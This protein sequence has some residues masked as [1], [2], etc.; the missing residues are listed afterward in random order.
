MATFITERKIFQSLV[1]LSTEQRQLFELLLKKQGEDLTQ[2]AIP[3]RMASE[4]IPLSYSQER[5]WTIAQLTPDTFVDNVPG[6]FHISG[7]LNLQVFEKSV[8]LLIE[9]NEI[10]RTT[11]TVLDRQPVQTVMTTF[12]PWM[13]TIDLSHVSQEE[14][15]ERA[16]SQAEAIARQPFNLSQDVLFRAIVF[17]LGEQEFLVL[18]VTHQ[19][20]TDGLSF[21]FLLQ[22]LAAL[23][24]AILVGDRSS[25]LEPSIQYADFAVWQRQWFSD[26]IFEPQ[27]AY[28]KQQLNGA[29]TQLK[30]PIYQSRQFAT[31]EAGCEKFEF[32][33]TLSDK[34]REL[35]RQQGVTSFMAFVALFQLILHRC[36][37]ENDIS[38]GTL[39]SSR[40]RRE[41]EKLVG[42]FSNNLLLRTNFS[43]DLSFSDVLAKI[44]ETTLDAYLYQDLPFQRLSASLASIPQFQILLLLRDSTTAQNLDLPDLQVR[45]F[46]VELGLTRMELSL[47][48]T[49]SGKDSIFGKLEYKSALFQ[50]STI[51]QIIQNLQALLENVT[52]NQALKIA[53]IVLPETIDCS[54]FNE[55]LKD[56]LATT[57]NSSRQI[58]AAT[59]EIEKKLIAV[60]SEILNHPQIGIHD[61]FFELGGHSLLAVKLF[62]EMEKRFGKNLPLSVLFQAP[63]ICQLADVV[64]RTEETVSWSPLVTI[65][66]GDFKKLPLFCV[67]G[68][69]FNVLIYRDVARNLGADQPVY[70]LQARGL[71]GNRPVHLSFESIAA[72]YIR[73]IQTVQPEGPY[74]LGGLSNG[75][76][77]ALEMA[78]QLRQQ[79]QEVI[80]LALFDTYGPDAIRL[81]PPLPRFLSSVDYLR[82]HM[83]P[84][85]LLKTRSQPQILL[86]ELQTVLGAVG[87]VL[88]QSKARAETLDREKK[89]A[90]FSEVHMQ[91][92]DPIFSAPGHFSAPSFLE[93]KLAQIS[94]YIL[95][96][97]SWAFLTPSTQLEEMDDVISTN[98]RSLEE[99][100]SKVQ[101]T[102]NAQP[103]PGKITVFKAGETPPGHQV[104]AKLGW[105]RI[106]QAGVEV[107][108]IPGNHTSIMASPLLA[109]KLRLCIEKAVGN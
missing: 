42:N 31:L 74:M 83:L 108:E 62:A 97:S 59:T 41:V 55:N 68:A 18:L 103:Y 38:I 21:R 13:E 81:L 48:I 40:S 43:G 96:R 52:E 64:Q 105:S 36:A 29:L 86:S 16:T 76:N 77:I 15:L 107:F 99:I 5:I 66:A 72:D 94:K 20:A 67:H 25:L 100:Y 92:S 3:K 98:L 19:F 50:T 61:N 35:C 101:K 93:Q 88:L 89:L 69:G 30:L 32:S 70:G 109:E 82:Q 78:Q 26:A 47:D 49:D 75:G 79:G 4:L 87:K 95:Q 44:R 7:N 1:E 14:R 60:W 9:R 6:A 102:Y 22:E 11:C 91:K 63:T 24:K 54:Q 27:L 56:K 17:C 12:K 104:D 8:H 90:F 57:Q 10:L 33:S 28:W 2:F 106:A 37:L 73:E 84:A 58:V 23:Y 53:D 65:E 80:L 46:P 34:L 39:M 85:Y 71:D 51:K 45:D